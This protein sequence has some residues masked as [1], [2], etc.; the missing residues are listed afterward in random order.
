M[1]AK[2]DLPT[3]R[4]TRAFALQGAGSVWIVETG[5]LDVFLAPMQSGS[6]AGAL[7][8]VAR[9]EAGGA[10]FA[11]PFDAESGLGFLAV[12]A[13]ETTVQAAAFDD[14]SIDERNE[15]SVPWIRSIAR[16]L[17]PVPAG[18]SLEQFHEWAAA[19]WIGRRR[20]EEQEHAEHL[21]VR[22]RAD[23]K[24]AGAALRKL[25]QPFSDGVGG[26]AIVGADQSPLAAACLAVGKAAGIE[27]KIPP[28]VIQG[29]AKDP[30]RAIA[31]FSAVRTRR[32]VLR[33]DWWRQDSGPMVAFLDE[34]NKPVALLPRKGRGYDLFDPADDARV[35]VNRGIAGKLNGVAYVFYRTFPH[36]SLTGW[37]VLRSGLK[38]CG[39]DLWGIAIAGFLASLLALVTPIATGIVFDSI[40]P[41]SERGQLLQAVVFIVASAVA[42]TFISLTRGYA[43]L[44]VEGKLDF[45]TQAAVWDRLLNLPTTF[46]RNYSS[47]DLANRGMAIS[48]IRAILSES[49]FTAIISGLFSVSSIFLLFYYSP[50]LTLV[51]V[52]LAGTALAVM[53][54]AGLIQFRWLREVAEN[55]GK[56]TGMVFEFVDGIAKFKVSGTEGRAFARWAAV[57][58]AQKGMNAS[59]R[60]IANCLSVFNASFPTVALVVIFSAV[61]GQIGGRAASLS[62]GGFLAF[63]VAFGQLLASVLALGGG[64][65]A[66]L[67]SVPRYTRVKPIFETLPEI[68]TGKAEPGELT[69]TIEVNHLAFRYSNSSNVTPLVLRDVSFSIRPGEFI[70][71]VGES[72]AGKSTM[73][74]LLMGFERPLSGAIYYDGQDLAGIDIQ[75]VRLQMGIVL[76]NGKLL[77]GDILTNIIGSAPLTVD[78]AWEAVRLAGLED[79]IKALPMGMYTMVSEGG[80][81]LSGGQRQRL[82]IARA[83][84]RKPRILIFDEATS[85]LDNR[86]QEIV[87]RAMEGMR[88]TRIVIAHRLSTIMKADR[89]LVLDGGTVVQSGAY[90][91]L[92]DQEGPFAELAR[93]QLA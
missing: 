1:T 24:V 52:A 35:R 58:S 22:T 63:N 60:R 16:Q 25:A 54:V 3:M 87:S 80:K 83:I 59:I 10:L 62:T 93:R 5:K 9:V 61:A 79:D 38:G 6:P 28:S 42:M 66:I 11:L 18:Q 81:G 75:E 34:G 44:R 71:L 13:A 72:G 45:A 46:F 20:Q 43:L 27:L 69:G 14:L 74:R 91:E 50:A 53:V 92:I 73:L 29:K 41:G 21:S 57:F 55:K 7:T 82:M 33:G 65:L 64:F 85:A 39:R 30:Q 89:I 19:A 8:H 26:V 86:T 77:P 51:A 88:A 67:R 70:A 37:E 17:P 31:R 78:D 15:L 76:Q 47:G 4:V 36:R 48:Q 23:E 68:D 49:V 2:G 90:S 12:P 84:V 32:L 56:L 40:I